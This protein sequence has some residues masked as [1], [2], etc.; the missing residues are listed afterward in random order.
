MAEALLVARSD[1]K[2][3]LALE[4]IDFLTKNA[5]TLAVFEGG[6]QVDL[7]DLGSLTIDPSGCI[8]DQQLQRI[9]RSVHST[10]QSGFALAWDLMPSLSLRRND[11]SMS[12]LD[13]VHFT[14]L[15]VKTRKQ[16]QK[17]SWKGRIKACH[18]HLWHSL[19]KFLSSSCELFVLRDLSTYTEKPSPAEHI[20]GQAMEKI[21]F[22]SVGKCLIVFLKLKHSWKY[23]NCCCFSY[24]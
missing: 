14:L 10:I 8:K 22:N 9:L 15:V 2:I 3:N 7:G 6:L 13:Y 18:D 5:I 16:Q 1:A 17:K 21:M 4:C 23:S 11:D 24:D 12:F 19:I 20:P